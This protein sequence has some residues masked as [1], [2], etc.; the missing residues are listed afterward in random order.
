MFRVSFNSEYYVKGQKGLFSSKIASGSLFQLFIEIDND[1][2][3]IS[4]QIYYINGFERHKKL[5]IP[6]THPRLSFKSRVGT[7]GK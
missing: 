4:H 6:Y 5:D 3:P 7:T 2:D 1:R